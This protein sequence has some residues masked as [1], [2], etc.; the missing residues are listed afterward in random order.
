MPVI[1]RMKR[2]RALIDCP[3]ALAHILIICSPLPHAARSAVP[4]GA[5]W[6]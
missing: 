5:F 6:S 1:E 2:V 4:G 3:D